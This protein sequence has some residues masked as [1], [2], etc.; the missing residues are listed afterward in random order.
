M[1]RFL[2]VFFSFFV[3]A[4][5]DSPIFFKTVDL[6]NLGG[7]LP[8]HLGETTFARPSRWADMTFVFLSAA[9]GDLEMRAD[10]K[11]A[12]FANEGSIAL[13]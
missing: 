5:P 4:F 1:T 8:S 7:I 3:R 2:I 6:R 12:T 10:A 9:Q 11:V 13:R